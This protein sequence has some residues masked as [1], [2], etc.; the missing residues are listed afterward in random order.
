[1]R[2]DSGL[3]C[4]P[5]I[6]LTGVGAVLKGSCQS[7]TK[8]LLL[9]CP[10]QSLCLQCEAVASYCDTGGFY[11]TKISKSE[12]LYL[13]LRSNVINNNNNNLIMGF[14]QSRAGPGVVV[15]EEEEEEGQSGGGGGGGWGW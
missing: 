14:G 4:G 1:M 8:S 5:V 6:P 3:T 12:I 13:S 7:H 15:G 11:C 10:T 9:I 2:G